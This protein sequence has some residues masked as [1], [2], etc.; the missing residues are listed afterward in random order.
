MARES[1]VGPGMNTYLDACQAV[2][3]NHIVMWLNSG[4]LVSLGI[5]MVHYISVFLTIGSMVMIDLR[6]LG[7]AGKNQTVT[8]IAD[9]Y[10]PWMWIGLG[11]L[12]CTG[13]SMLLGDAI[14]FC[15][16]GVFGVNM[17]VTV[18]AAVFG[19]FIRKRASFW[20]QPSGTPWGAKLVAG[21]SIL[22]WVGTILTAVEVP[23]LSRVP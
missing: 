11:T 7:L 10:A 17:L 22:L 23:A 4:I 18:I 5:W 6:I 3:S 16:N 2:E 8:E 20:E 15:T 13:V 21:V 9:F 12:F 14:L 1:E 19:V